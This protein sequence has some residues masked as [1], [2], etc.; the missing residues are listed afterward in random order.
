MKS[1]IDLHLHTTCSD[2]S[3]TPLELIAKLSNLGIKLCSITD[4]DSIKA[5]DMLES[6]LHYHM[7][8]IQGVELSFVHNDYI[9]HILAY[10][11]D[12]S[13]MA[14]ELGKLYTP[15]KL[16]EHEQEMLNNFFKRCKQTGLIIDDT[17][18]IEKGTRSE[19]FNKVY[20]SLILTPKNLEICPSLISHTKFYW[21]ECMNKDSKFFIH[22]SKGIPNLEEVLDIIKR[23]E[24][25]AV[26][27]HPFQYPI[28]NNSYEI[29]KE[30]INLAIKLGLDGIEVYHK[31]A[32]KEQVNELI[33]MANKNN[34]FITG[35]SDYHGNKEIHDNGITELQI[36]KFLDSVNCCIFEI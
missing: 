12:I 3:N 33:D 17:I 7:K 8:M 26:L 19:A 14:S 2:G 20:D 34:L 21:H 28:K 22:C 27:A 9:R 13:K 15:K 24:G 23:C 1:S 25:L 31:S 11:F 5:Y 30:V 32:T 4:H 10:N 35:G 16:F 36:R 29:N 6:N 18:K